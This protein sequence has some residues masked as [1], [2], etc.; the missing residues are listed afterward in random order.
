MQRCIQKICL[1]EIF[2]IRRTT[3]L[4]SYTQKFGAMDRLARKG[5]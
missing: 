4:D 1:K 3:N 5:L 2:I